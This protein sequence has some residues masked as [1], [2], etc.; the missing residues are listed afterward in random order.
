MIRASAIRPVRRGRASDIVCYRCGIVWDDH[1]YAHVKGA[2]CTDCREILADEGVD[3]T[4]FIRP[5]K[6][7]TVAA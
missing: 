4:Q 7:E 2:P 6:R 1:R 5:E 3:L